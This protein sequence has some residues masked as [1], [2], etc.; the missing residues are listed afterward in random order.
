MYIA[1]TKNSD[2]DRIDALQTRIEALEAAA[3]I[4]SSDSTGTETLPGT[5]SVVP[6]TDT[7]VP[8]TGG[9]LPDSTTVP[10]TGTTDGSGL[11][12]P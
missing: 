6:E 7:T 1:L 10:P 2:G 9:T 12:V 5:D 8:D 11:T 4:P 3:G